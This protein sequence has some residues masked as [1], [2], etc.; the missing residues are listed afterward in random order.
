MVPL[1]LKAMKLGVQNSLQTD[2]ATMKLR[3]YSEILISNTHHRDNSCASHIAVYLVKGVSWP[4]SVAPGRIPR[5]TQWPSWSG[6]SLRSD[7]VRGCKLRVF[8]MCVFTRHDGFT[9]ATIWRCRIPLD[10][11]YGPKKLKWLSAILWKCNIPS[12]HRNHLGW[13]K[14]CTCF[15]TGMKWNRTT[16]RTS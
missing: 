8:S 12:A 14:L 1:A 16:G 4:V 3:N 7:H 15:V 13:Q 10:P 5:L 11:I 2:L 9:K 6:G